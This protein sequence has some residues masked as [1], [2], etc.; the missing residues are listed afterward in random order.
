MID[1]AGDQVSALFDIDHGLEFSDFFLDDPLIWVSRLTLFREIRPDEPT[2]QYDSVD[3]VLAGTPVAGDRWTL[4]LAG[5]D[6]TYI[7]QPFDTLSQVTSGLAGVIGAAFDVNFDD[8]IL[9]IDGS[10]F[11]IAFGAVDNI[12]V[13]HSTSGR[14]GRGSAF[15]RRGRSGRRRREYS[16][17]GHRCSG[18]RS[19]RRPRRRCLVRQEAM[20]GVTPRTS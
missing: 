20:G 9:S 6:F 14:R 4:T 15:R 7:V 19:G 1:D 5:A 18:C 16:Q 8:N 12:G 2:A 17:L 13:G 10:T 3:V 11:T